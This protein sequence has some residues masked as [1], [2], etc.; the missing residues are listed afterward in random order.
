MEG[1]KKLEMR[2]HRLRVLKNNADY[3]RRHGIPVT[4]EHIAQICFEANVEAE[5]KYFH[6][7]YTAGTKDGREIHKEGV[8]RHV[9]DLLTANPF[10][11]VKIHIGK[12]STCLSCA[13][14][15]PLHC[16]ELAQEDVDWV[17]KAERAATEKGYC[18][19]IVREPHPF[20]PDEQQRAVLVPAI[21]VQQ[22]ILGD[23]TRRH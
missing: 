3:C 12:D 13:K 7:D 23:I 17:Q 15:G 1:E 8:R 10:A 6:A 16:D 19:K 20:N 9:V 4:P 5:E 18:V 22:Y 11:W 2:G 14:K 21:V